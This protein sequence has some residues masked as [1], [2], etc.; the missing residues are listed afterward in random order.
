MEGRQRGGEVV[1]EVVGIAV[2]L[3]DVAG[4]RVVDG[5]VGRVRVLVGGQLHHAGEAEL[6]RDLFDGLPGLVAHEVVVPCERAGLHTSIIPSHTRR[7]PGCSRV[8]TTSW[9]NR[10]AGT[11]STTRWSKVIDRLPMVR[12][13]T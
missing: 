6:T 1:A 10:P 9:R 3:G 11:P 4:H 8:R 7:R 12:I 13:T 2:T 5:W